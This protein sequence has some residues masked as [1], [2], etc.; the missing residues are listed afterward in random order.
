M[1]KQRRQASGAGP[2]ARLAKSVLEF[3]QQEADR[4]NH[5]YLGTEHVLLALMREPNSAAAKVLD[6]LGIDLEKVRLAVEG[7]IGR[8]ERPVGGE[9]PLSPRAKKAMELAV[10]EARRLKHHDVRAE[11]LLLGLVREG[12]GVAAKLLESFGVSR[13]LV[14][15]QVVSLLKKDSVVTCRVN[16]QDLEAIDMLI[17]VGIC[18]TRSDAASWLIRGG[19]E[20]NQALFEK[21]KET[22]SDIRRLRQEAQASARQLGCADQIPAAPPPQGPPL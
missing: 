7:M 6:N 13:D 17:E 21:V 11:H 1:S 15:A 3:G 2:L 19:I 12:E 4:L 9:I 16:H 14:Q 18:S 5:N 8:G 22:I 20:A 10:E